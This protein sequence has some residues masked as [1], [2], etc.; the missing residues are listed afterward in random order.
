MWEAR[1]RDP[2]GKEHK[3]RFGRKIDGERWLDEATAGMVTGT[4]IDPQAGKMTFR[5]YAESWRSIQVHRESTAAHYETMLRRHTYPVL[6]DLRL[7]E[8][9]PYDIQAWVKT[10]SETLKPRTV[11]VVHGIVSSCF[12][13]AIRARRLASNPCEGTRL[14]EIEKNKVVPLTVEQ[15]T[16]LHSAIKPE[17]KAL[18]HLCAATGMRQGEVFGLTA[19]RVDFLRGTVTVDRQAVYLA[20]QPIR[21][22]PPKRPASRR[23]IPVPRD[24]VEK[25]S[26]HISEHGLGNSGL[27]FHADD[28]GFVRRST[29]SAKI[30]K[31]ARE[32]AGLPGDVGVHAL[33]HFYASLLIRHGESVKTVQARLGHASASETLDTYSHLW[34]DSDERT[35]QAVALLPFGEVAT[36]L[37]Q[38][39]GA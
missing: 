9:T 4:Y 38:T 7:S 2:T 31:P 25:L 3:K 33:R 5:E 28:G 10:L 36:D 30:W 23:D 32:S 26:A 20:K 11:A 6:G 21:F 15:V 18:V 12:K 29:F 34:P 19:D 24:V 14:P 13:S 27:I 1:Y 39:E 8:V 37:R 17:F 16:A 22:G 35:R